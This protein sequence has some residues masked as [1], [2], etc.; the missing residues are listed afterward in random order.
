MTGSTGSLLLHPGQTVTGICGDEARWWADWSVAF[1]KEG[2]L[3]VSSAQ[4]LRGGCPGHDSRNEERVFSLDGVCTC[5][6]QPQFLNMRGP[7]L[8]F[9]FSPSFCFI[10]PAKECLCW[11]EC[12]PA[13]Q[14]GFVF[15]QGAA[16]TAA[17]N[18]CFL[19]LRHNSPMSPVTPPTHRVFPN[20]LSLSALKGQLGLCFLREAFE[21]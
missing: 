19:H 14:N 5:S 15:Q 16:S 2:A 21:E 18:Q 3:N 1:Q 9:L 6:L 10:R 12:V 4:T 7:R 13:W 17:I 8:H 20:L 11:E